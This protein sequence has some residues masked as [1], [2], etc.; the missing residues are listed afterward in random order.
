MFA[1][2]ITNWTKLNILN[3]DFPNFFSRNPLNRDILGSD[4]PSILHATNADATHAYSKLVSTGLHR[5]QGVPVPL[6]QNTKQKP[7]PSSGR[8][9]NPLPNNITRRAYLGFGTVN[10]HF[11]NSKILN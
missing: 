6:D 9:Q 2:E 4:G 5:G 10:Q 11:L 1:V 7:V 3:F 8:P